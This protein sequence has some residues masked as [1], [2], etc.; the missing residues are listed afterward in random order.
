MLNKK[1]EKA[2]NDQVN[3]ELYSAY[4]YLS[5]AACFQAMNLPGLANWMRVQTQ[6]EM[7]HAV[8]FYDF[9][10]Q[11]GGSVKL[12]AIAAPPVAWASPLKAF[13]HTLSHEEAV[14]ARINNLVS[15]ATSAKDYATNNFLQWFVSE[16]VEEEANA[17]E[18]VQRLK[19]IGKSAEALLLL[20]QELAKRVFV[21]PAA[22]AAAGA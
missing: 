4:L 15:A 20:D 14:T 18:L 16:Q 10:L 9:I 6:E 7:F 22:P 13:E 1:M 3:A 19:L 17:N 2:L 12:A 5:M 11:R 8:K 21:M